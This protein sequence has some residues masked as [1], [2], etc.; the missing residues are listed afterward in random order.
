MFL[1]NILKPPFL[2]V[3]FVMYEIPHY[4]KIYYVVNQKLSEEVQFLVLG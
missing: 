2:L 3:A 1:F 4:V